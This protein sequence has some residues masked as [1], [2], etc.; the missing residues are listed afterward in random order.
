MRIQVFWDTT[1]YSWGNPSTIMALR[2]SETSV[3][4]PTAQCH[5]PE[6]VNPHQH[7]HEKLRSYK[8]NLGQRFK[9]AL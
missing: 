4:R 5:N 2:R 9:K 6:D 1:L 3:S 7:R 8:C